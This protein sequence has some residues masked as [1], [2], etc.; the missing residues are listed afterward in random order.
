MDIHYN[1]FISYRHHPQ[2][3]KVA[4]TIHRSLEHF[5]V[6]GALKKKLKNTKLRLFRD[7]EELPITSNLSDDITKALHNSDFLIVICSTHTKESMWVQRE[8]ETFLQ[9]HDYSKVFTVLVDGEPYDTIPAVLCSQEEVDSITG[10]KKLVPLEPLSCDWRVN[11]RKAHRE[12]LPRLAAALLGCGY[13]ELRQRQRQYRMRRAI[14]AATV[15]GSLVL[16]FSGYVLHNSLQLQKANNRLVVAND[17]IQSNYMT[18]LE[19]QS[20]YLS[21]AAMQNLDD[22]DRMLAMALAIEALPKYDGERPYVTQAEYAL[23]DALYAYTSEAQIAGVGRISCDA[24]I[25]DFVATDARDRMFVVDQLDTLSTWDLTNYSKLK[26]VAVP[27]I[28]SDLLITPDDTVIF[29]G[30]DFLLYCYDK[31]LNLLWSKENCNEIAFSQD[32]NVVLMETFDNTILFLNAATGEAAYPDAQIQL[33]ELGSGWAVGFCQQVYDLRSP[34][35][36]KYTQYGS[37]QQI[38][39]WNLQTEKLQKIASY[40]ENYTIRHTGYTSQGNVV[41]VVCS[42]VNDMAGIYADMMTYS[43]AKNHVICYSPEGTQLW[44]A[45]LTSYTFSNTLTLGT[46]PN[47]ENLFLQ[48]DNLLAIIDENTGNVLST[49]ETGAI[50]KWVQMDQTYVSILLEDGSLGSYYYGDNYFS[51][52]RYFK[53]NLS[54]GFL[55]KGAFIN[56][57]MSRDILVYSNITDDNWKSFQG[58]YGS[59]IRQRVTKDHL[60]AI[61]S[62]SGICVFD[63]QEQKL[64]WTLEETADDDFSLIQFSGDFLWIQNSKAKQLVKM[65]LQTGETEAFPL[66]EFAEENVGLSYRSNEPPVM[67]ADAIY[68]GAINLLYS[69]YYLVKFDLSSLS[70]SCVFLQT[71]DASLPTDCKL[72]AVVGET[73]YL[74]SEKLSTL[75]TANITT[76]AYQIYLEGLTTS[77]IIQMMPDGQSCMV[78]VGNQ[79]RFLDQNG[80]LLFEL[81]LTDAK[82]VSGFLHNKKVYLLT[83]GGILSIY[84]LAGTK[85]SDINPELYSTFYSKLSYGYDPREI[86]WSVTNSGDL[87]VNIFNAGNLIHG[88]TN[89]LR[90]WIPNCVAYQAQRNEIITTGTNPETGEKTLLAYPCYSTDDIIAM[91]QEA[92]GTYTLTQEQM[93]QYGIC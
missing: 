47:S 90:A 66:P 63:T 3:I 74:Y 11:R 59:S 86:T 12:E 7:K 25:R 5:R 46:I 15:A 65:D 42:Q 37:E 62:Y 64:L 44:K 1:A 82:A 71:A 54:D 77:P 57:S 79:V 81:A 14:T 41:S 49:C 39:A 76:G 10:E 20:Q 72:L 18:A 52:F 19:N 61:C 53:E 28:S 6:P 91:A 30:E 58:S 69:E 32:R 13:D 85:L 80:S 75:Y 24:L 88:K 70:A 38:L 89:Q 60:V 26:S 4:E 34:I 33:P 87:L 8:I 31:E 9:T 50:P 36:L 27:G 2:D 16:A 23:A 43:P 48:I 68:S 29:Q 73:A 92:L 93:E 51:S 67:T 55:G 78:S 40:P 45:D 56:Q 35:L 22:G 17:K 83:D 21:S 84:N